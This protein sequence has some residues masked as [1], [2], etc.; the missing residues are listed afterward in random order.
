MVEKR[1]KTMR[2]TMRES[3]MAF[4]DE[5]SNAEE[6]GV[7]S[8]VENS[9]TEPSGWE[10]RL[11]KANH[12]LAYFWFY[13]VVALTV[14]ALISVSVKPYY[15]DSL[16][17]KLLKNF[18]MVLVYEGLPYTHTLELFGYLTWILMAMSALPIIW[19]I[20]C[21]YL[22]KG[23]IKHRY[24]EKPGTTVLQ[25]IKHVGLAVL[26]FIGG[27]YSFL[28]VIRVFSPILVIDGLR[29]AFHFIV[30]SVSFFIAFMGFVMV[31]M[32]LLAKP[33]Q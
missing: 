13:L 2:N 9:G 14:V 29:F 17:S 7:A 10:Q 6:G 4:V 27:L 32:V 30:A 16:S 33:R 24:K 20:I 28:E 15:F 5:K 23:F 26:M 21:S 12:F 3:V 19:G 25:W 22:Y 1:I 18:P 11:T 8:S 31:I